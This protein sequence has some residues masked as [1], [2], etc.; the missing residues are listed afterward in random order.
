MSRKNSVYVVGGG[1]DFTR[2]FVAEGWEITQDIFSANLVQFTGGADVSPEFYGQ[3]KHP[4][5]HCNKV[6]DQR[7][8]I[9]FNIALKNKIPMAGVCRGG[10]FLH[11]MNGG[12]LWQH[13]DKHAEYG[14]HKVV[15]METGESFRASST[16]HQQMMQ[17]S[18]ISHGKVL[19]MANESTKKEKIGK[20]G[21]IIS[22]LGFKGNDIEILFYS[23][24]KSLCFQPHPEYSGYSDLTNRYFDYMGKHLFLR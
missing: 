17:P 7:E 19:G 4:F 22:L 20:D 11:V 12:I 8:R 15:D 24:S 6:R 16:H 10:Q 13:V 9:I 3:K 1:L 21:Q 14:S 18:K 23:K 2:M 5:T